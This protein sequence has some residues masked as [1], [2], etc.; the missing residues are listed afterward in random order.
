MKFKVVWINL[1]M[2]CEYDAEFQNGKYALF[3]TER[4]AESWARRTNARA[5]VIHGLLREWRVETI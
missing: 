4:A 2:K 3:K 5:G 1:L